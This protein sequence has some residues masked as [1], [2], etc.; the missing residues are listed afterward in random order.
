MKTKTLIFKSHKLTGVQQNALFDLVIAFVSQLNDTKLSIISK[1]CGV[2]L[3]R[4]E[5]KE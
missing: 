2:E 5:D 4:R 1:R 3:T